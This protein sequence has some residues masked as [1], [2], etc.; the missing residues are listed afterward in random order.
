LRNAKVATLG[1]WLILGLVG[2]AG[3]GAEGRQVMVHGFRN[4]A[5]GLEVRQGTVGFVVGFFPD[6]VDTAPNGENRTTWFTK[7]GLFYYPF[8]VDAG[9]SG[10]FEPYLGLSLVQGL[11]NGWNVAESVTHGSGVT[12][13]GGLRWATAAGLDLRLGAVLLAGFD[14][15]L[16]WNPAPGIGWIVPLGEKE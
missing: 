1:W 5:T 11:G 2:A 10:R 16:N 13:D 14:G 4:P 3:L 15:R 8:G 12:L 6:I 9:A 7:T